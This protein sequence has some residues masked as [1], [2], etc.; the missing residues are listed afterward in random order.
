MEIMTKEKLEDT[1]IHQIGKQNAIRFSSGRNSEKSKSML[2][3]VGQDD[4]A[5]RIG[6]KGFL[7]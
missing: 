6:K 7:D 5:N 4:I 1:K 2:P 3:S